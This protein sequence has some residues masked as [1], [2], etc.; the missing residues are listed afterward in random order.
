MIRVLIISLIVFT[1]NY[2]IAQKI[3]ISRIQIA[4][5]TVVVH[6]ALE[7][8]NP[9]NEY[10]VSLFA[11]ADNFKHPLKKVSGD[12]GGEILA[13]SARRIMWNAREELGSFNGKLAFEVHAKMHIPIAKFLELTSATKFRRGK[14]HVVHWKPGGSQPVHIELLKGERS[15]VSELNHPNNGAFAMPIPMHCKI[16]NDYK[17]RITD[18]RNPEEVVYSQKFSIGRKIPL[19]AKIVAPAAIILIAIFSGGDGGS[20]NNDIVAPGFPQSN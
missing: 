5:D 19:A 2:T 15:I 16:G 8:A 13:G 4:G 12:V 6:Y 11:S 20:S 3:N 1:T 9:N 14:K 7:D 17:V 10:R 18:A